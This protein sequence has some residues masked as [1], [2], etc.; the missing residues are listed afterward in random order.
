[1][2]QHQVAVPGEALGVACDGEIGAQRE[3][4]LADNGGERVVDGDER[5]LLVGSQRERGDVADIQPGIAG[6]LQPEQ[7]RTSQMLALRVARSGRESQ[8]D[9]K[10]TE[11]PLG[12]QTRRVVAIGS[13][14]A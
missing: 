11:V 9:A 13:R 6:R 8:C 1:M 7:R 4:L 3:R 2:P 12:Q 5:A 14:P 10:L